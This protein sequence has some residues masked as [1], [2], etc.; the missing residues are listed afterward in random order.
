[1]N[2]GCRPGAALGPL[3]ANLVEDKVFGIDLRC[4]CAGPTVEQTRAFE[5]AL[6]HIIRAARI[7]RQFWALDLG[8][9]TAPGRGAAQRL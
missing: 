2:G 9:A 3:G 7:S 5:A 1:M 4:Q 6:R 8:P